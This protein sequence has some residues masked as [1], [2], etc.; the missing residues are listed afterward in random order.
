MELGLLQRS[1]ALRA[2]VGAS[3]DWW[4]LGEGG[5]EVG[6]EWCDVWREVSYSGCLGC[7]GCTGVCG[8]VQRLL[9]VSG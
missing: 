5:E 9:G 6:M 7:N 3:L 2:A 4:R 1:V 8:E